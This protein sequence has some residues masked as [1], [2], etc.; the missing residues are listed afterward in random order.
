MSQHWGTNSALFIF[1][2]SVK[3]LSPGKVLYFP[4][5][6]CEG[7]RILSMAPAGILPL[8]GQRLPYLH[9]WL[10]KEG[11]KMKKYSNLYGKNGN[12]TK[13]G[14]PLDGL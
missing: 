2:S 4:V 9:L 8:W 13:L 3:Y 7:Q 1:V 12:Q 14:W 11:P 6:V 5:S 10:P